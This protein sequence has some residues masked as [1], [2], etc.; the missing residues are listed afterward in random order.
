MDQL[1]GEA[2]GVSLFALWIGGNVGTDDL[3]EHL[4]NFAGFCVAAL[5]GLFRED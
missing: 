3:A 2:H 1:G 5:H 4:Q